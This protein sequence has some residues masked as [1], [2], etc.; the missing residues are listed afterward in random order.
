MLADNLNILCTWLGLSCGFIE[1][2]LETSPGISGTDPCRCLSTDACWPSS[3]AFATLESKLS[4]P[5]VTPLPPATP[6]YSSLESE[7]C[8]AV[9]RLWLDGWWRANSSGATQHPNFAEFATPEGDTEVCY[10]NTTLGY[11]CGR[12]SIPAVGVDAR[13]VEDIQLAINFA[14]ARNL[15]VVVKNTGHDYLGRS[16]ARGAFLIWTHHLTNLT[17]HDTFK[18]AGAPEG[19][20]YHDVMTLGAGVQWQDAYDAA[21]ARGRNI[22]GGISY[23]GSVGAA[24]GWVQGGGHSIIAPL[25]GLGVDN[26]VEMSIVISTGKHL[27]VNAHQHSDL[28]WALRGGG[29]GTWGVVVS[30]TYRTHPAPPINAA[31]FL[32]SINASTPDALTTP[33]PTLHKLFAELVRLTPALADAGWAGYADI[34]ASADTG[35]PALRVAY[36][37]PADAPAAVPLMERFYA[38]ARELAESSTLAQGKLRVATAVVSPLANFGAWET[39]IFRGKDGQGQVG[40]NVELGS[41]LLPRELIKRNHT[42]VADAVLGLELPFIGFYTV[43]GGVVSKVDPDATGIHPAWRKALVHLVFGSSWPEAAS[44]D[45]VN[46]IREKNKKGEAVFREM[47]PDGGAYFNEASLYQVDPKSDFFGSHYQKLRA[48]KKKYDPTG[49]FVV[50]GGVGSEDWDADLHCRVSPHRTSRTRSDGL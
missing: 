15:R 26:V 4:T 29:G 6:C 33:S 37:A 39:M 45:V 43:T 24:G 42:K 3:T 28:F 17:Y 19:E 47:T 30:V 20:V 23:G 11:P 22:V 8:G 13:S 50:H 48:I 7:D 49:L 41:R 12:G 27:V 1:R 21:F 32:T 35:H 2:L 18:P 38:Y 36:I 46:E 40:L 5:L 16:T 14:A 10:V 44:S 34:L 9:Q 31:F 25:Y